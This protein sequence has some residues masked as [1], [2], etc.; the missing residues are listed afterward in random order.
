M[1]LG[2]VMNFAGFNPIKALIYAAVLNG[3]VAPVILVLIL[4]LARNKRVM[5]E[6]HNKKITAG[7][8]WFLAALMTISGV[9]AIYV[10]AS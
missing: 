7:I 4:L 6:W 8:G 9:A 3:I 2:L 1:F 5:G 10:L